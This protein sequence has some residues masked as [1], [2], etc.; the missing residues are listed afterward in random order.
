MRK[1]QAGFHQAADAGEQRT[2]PEF[3]VLQICPTVPS[4]TGVGAGKTFDAS[5]ALARASR[6]SVHFP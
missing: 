4:E 1:V 2:S 6:K 5:H 3:F